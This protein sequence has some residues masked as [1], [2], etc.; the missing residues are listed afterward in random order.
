[1][2]NVHVSTTLRIGFQLLAINLG[3]ILSYLMCSC[4]LLPNVDASVGC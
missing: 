2:S 1:M 4:S 3:D